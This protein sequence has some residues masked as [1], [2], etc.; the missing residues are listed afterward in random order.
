MNVAGLLVLL[1]VIGACICAIASLAYHPGR[2][3]FGPGW[4]LVVLS[5]AVALIG[6]GA[7]IGKPHL[8]S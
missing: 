3:R 7:L 5:I 1:G 2:S 6:I 8:S 4:V